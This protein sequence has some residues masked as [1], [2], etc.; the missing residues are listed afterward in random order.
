[1][2]EADASAEAARPCDPR[3]ER[4]RRLICEAAIAELSEVGYGAMS[5]ESIARRAGVGKATVYRHWNGK[6][7][8][9]ASALEQTKDEMELPVTETVRERIVLLIRWVAT[10]LADVERSGALPALISASVYDESVR[11]FHHRFSSERRRVLVGLLDEGVAA[12]EFDLGG[13]DHVLVAETLVGPLFYERMNTPSP[14]DPARVT[15]VVDLVLGPAAS[16]S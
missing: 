5:V 9:V 6:L 11:D 3:V 4:S 8:L 10:Y 7:D 1:M 15:E 2:S 13:A 16:S 12:G 14:F